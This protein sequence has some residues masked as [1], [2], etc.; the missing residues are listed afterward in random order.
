MDGYGLL[1]ITGEVLYVLASAVAVRGR[2]LVCPQGSSGAFDHLILF[3]L[4][5]YRTCLFWKWRKA[6][7]LQIDQTCD[8][9]VFVPLEFSPVP[10]V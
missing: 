8:N 9:L 6:S 2:V 3:T 10:I 4:I 7:W 1:Y 5:G